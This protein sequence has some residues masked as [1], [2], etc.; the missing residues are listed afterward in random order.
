MTIA[1]PIDRRYIAEQNANNIASLIGFQTIRFFTPRGKLLRKNISRKG[2]DT[3]NQNFLRRKW[4][5]RLN[6]IFFYLK[7]ASRHT[8]KKF[9]FSDSIFVLPLSA[10]K[11]LSNG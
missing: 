3:L 7:Y 1:W 6:L 10:F 4:S 5:N 2:A 11:T 8:Q 9:I